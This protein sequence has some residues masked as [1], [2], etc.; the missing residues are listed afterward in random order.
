MN[1]PI[2]AVE[3]LYRHSWLQSLSSA[4]RPFLFLLKKSPMSCCYVL[5]Q[6]IPHPFLLSSQS[7]MRPAAKARR[8]HRRHRISNSR[9]QNVWPPADVGDPAHQTPVAVAVSGCSSPQLTW[10]NYENYDQDWWSN[11]IY[12]IGSIYIYMVT[13]TINIPQMLAYI[14]YMDPMGM[15]IPS[16]LLL[17]TQTA[18]AI[19][20]PSHGSATNVHTQ[21]EWWRGC[22]DALRTR[23]R[24]HRLSWQ[25]LTVDLHKVAR[26]GEVR[27]KKNTIAILD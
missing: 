13:F 25:M 26:V 22:P 4:W 8:C 16:I 1:F 6:R 14:P 21:L 7:V 12:P 10:E 20:G 11:L 5:L 19:L 3:N 23:R 2:L 15:L 18:L 27:L 24:F 9:V 17:V